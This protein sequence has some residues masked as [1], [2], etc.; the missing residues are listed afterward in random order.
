MF[1]CNLPRVPWQYMKLYPVLSRCP[2]R[3]VTAPCFPLLPACRELQRLLPA[4]L[5]RVPHLLCPAQNLP[6]RSDKPSVKRTI[7]IGL[8]KKQARGIQGGCSCGRGRADSEVFLSRDAQVKACNLTLNL[9]RWSLNF[10]LLVGREGANMPPVGQR[11]SLCGTM[12]DILLRD[13]LDFNYM[14]YL[15]VWCVM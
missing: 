5:S 8:K 11:V 10:L 6:D 1:N 4:L 13:N 2:R 3:F 15:H 7:N 12:W 9:T 14:M